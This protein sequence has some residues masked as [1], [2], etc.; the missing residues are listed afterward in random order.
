MVDRN[1][2]KSL[3]LKVVKYLDYSEH[4]NDEDPKTALAILK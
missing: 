1:I 4:K 3:Q 2:Q